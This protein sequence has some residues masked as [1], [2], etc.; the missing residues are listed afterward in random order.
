MVRD[1]TKNSSGSKDSKGFS[2]GTPEG[3]EF[4]PSYTGKPDV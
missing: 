1:Y 3:F 4:F 2:S